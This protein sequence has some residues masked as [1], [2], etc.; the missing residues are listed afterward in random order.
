MGNFWSGLVC[1]ESDGWTTGRRRQGDERTR[2][3]E[4][5]GATTGGRHF[6]GATVVPSSGLGR[7]E[8][9]FGGKPEL[10]TAQ[11]RAQDDRRPSRFGPPVVC[12]A[13]TRPSHRPY[14]RQG[15]PY[16][17]PTNTCLLNLAKLFF[18]HG[19]APGDLLI[20]GFDQGQ[21]DCIVLP[22]LSGQSPQSTPLDI[23]EI[24]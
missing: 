24:M 8:V 15:R 7:S 14:H 12:P 20:L 11:T 5:D 9:R 1:H 4:D 2:G 6:D 3:R 22:L 17:L 13:A 18:L 23:D 21:H 19:F 10:R 16:S